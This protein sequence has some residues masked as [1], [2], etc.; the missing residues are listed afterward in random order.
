MAA[1]ARTR[2]L[3]RSLLLGI[4]VP[5][6][7]F[8]VVDTV[9]LYRQTLQAVTVAYDRT[10]LASAKAIGELL[11]VQGEGPDAVFAASIPYSA[12]EPFETDGRI[13]LT[14]RVSTTRGQ[15]IAG[16]EDLPPWAGH[17]PDQGPYATLVD[18]YDAQYRGEAVRIA[19]LLQPVASPTGKGMAAVQV[20]ETL[21]LRQSAATQILTQTLVRQC[22]LI[23][24][25]ALVVVLVVQRVTQPVRTLSN[26]LAARSDDDLTPLDGTDLPAEVGP[27]ADA[28]N[29][30]MVRL[31]HMLDH[32]KRFVR[33]AAHH[34]RTP[35]AVLKVQVQSAQ[36]GDMPAATALGEIRQTV[37]RATVL[38]NQM[39]SLA[40]VEQLRQQKDF[41][42]VAMADC[43]RT[44]A[45]EL[46]PL[47]AD[48]DLD[49]DIDTQDCQ[50]L[51]HEWM[52]RELTRNVLQNAIHHTP[53][54]GA[55]RVRVQ[56]LQEQ[57]V[58]Q[59]DDA[60]PGI[61]AALRERLFQPFSAGSS[62]SGSG[63]GLAIVQE[64]VLALRGTIQLHNRTADGGTIGLSVRISIPRLHTPLA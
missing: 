7:L 48:K 3:R 61:P 17:L 49:F 12:L 31:Q 9:S 8:V 56:T 16:A 13:Q 45:L 14:Y 58:L 32:Q 28:T 36:R 40:K 46:A 10:L 25:I 2:S 53:L 37:D 26:R 55:L 29:Q 24:V 44:I 42:P 59:I 34:L 60:G 30:L 57:A 35:L 11:S 39:L 5:V 63:L 1:L 43:V 4:L 19:V 52:L 20:V 21:Q 38:A 51:G 15:L 18:F 23:A 50:V 33:D 6:L 41:A 54:G 62:R 22:I 27:L 47:I 64:I